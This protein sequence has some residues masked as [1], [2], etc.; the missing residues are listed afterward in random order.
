M[1]TGTDLRFEWQVDTVE[2]CFWTTDVVNVIKVKWNSFST[3]RFRSVMLK[4]RHRIRCIQL[5]KNP[6]LRHQRL[7]HSQNQKSKL[8]YHKQTVRRLTNL[9]CLNHASLLTRRSTTGRSS[10]LFLKYFPKLERLVSCS[11]GQHLSIRAQAA[12]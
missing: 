4:P 1:K 6:I 8:C 10:S 9:H 11:G 2:P 12:V 7:A 3:N 5:S